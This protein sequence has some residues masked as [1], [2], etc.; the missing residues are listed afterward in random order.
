MLS[1]YRPGRIPLVL[2]H[3]TFSS[4]ATWAELVNELE[5]DP[6]LSTRYQPWLFIYPTGNPIVYSAGVLVE[7]LR[8]A[9]PRST[10][11]ASIPRSRR[12]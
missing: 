8:E 4:P 1:P 9:V 10:P 2:I 11:R 7:T 12:W 6:E 5:N 3:G